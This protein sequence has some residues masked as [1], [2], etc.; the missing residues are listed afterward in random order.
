MATKLTNNHFD[1]KS[2][3]KMRV[4]LAFQIL[5]NSVAMNI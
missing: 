5:S 4:N 3:T 2:F 1:L